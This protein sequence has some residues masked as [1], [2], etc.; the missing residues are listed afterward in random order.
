LDLENKDSEIIKK[1]DL[2]LLH[3]QVLCG[4]YN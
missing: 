2:Y 3:W 1:I 4:Y